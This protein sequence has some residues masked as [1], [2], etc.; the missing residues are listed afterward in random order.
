MIASPDD[1]DARYGSKNGTTWTGYKV[2][3]TESCDEESP[4]LITHV[5]TTVATTTDA[6]VTEQIQD[7]LVERDLTPATH[8]VDGGYTETD[9]LLSSQKKGIDLV[10]PIRG[11]SSWQA[12]LEGGYDQSKFAIDWEQMVVTCPE[13]KTS[14]YWKQAK[15]ASGKPTIHFAF[16]LSDCSTCAARALCTRA[17]RIGRHLTVHPQAAYEALQQARRRQTTEAFKELYKERA[18]IEGTIS[19]A[20]NAMG[21]RRA[22]YRGLVRTHL[23]HLATA[24]AINLQRIADWMMGT[25]PEA[26]RISPFAALILP[27]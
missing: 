13:S 4:R 21:I 19:L 3:L 7:D 26:A 18:G 11:D 17:E 25:R 9:L 10:G 15:T 24:A 20:V 1:L 22:R 6:S 14:I 2:H 27:I 5:E 16:S 8:L 12:N 23:Q